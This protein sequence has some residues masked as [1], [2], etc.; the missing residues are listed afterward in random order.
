MKPGND[1]E[2]TSFAWLES[3]RLCR[4]EGRIDDMISRYKGLLSLEKQPAEQL[5]AEANYW[6]G[7][8]I[9]K[10]SAGKD[11]SANQSREAV[12]FLE[13]ARKLRPDTYGKHAGLLL[14]LVYFGN[15]DVPA[16]NA[17]L[18]LAIKKKYAA[19]VPE[20]ALSWAGMQAFNSEEYQR[21]ERYLKFVANPEEPR[22]T[23]KEIW[24]YLA[25][26]QLETGSFKDALN[27]VNNVLEVEDNPAWKADG[28][29]DKG[30]ALLELNRL[31]EAREAADEGLSMVPS[32]RTLAGLR[33]LSGDLHA[34][35]SELEKAGAQYL[36]LLEFHADQDLRPKALYRLTQVLEKQGKP[37]E[38][39]KYYNQLASDFPD[40]RPPTPKTAPDQ[41]KA[42]RAPDKTKPAA[43]APR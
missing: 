26:A 15:Q 37:E 29:L 31:T 13:T 38:A 41:P 30:R 24:R 3:A 36:I 27:A 1:A 35:A 10:K 42:P 11:P 21:A 19:D 5:V 18:D 33:M 32:G 22:E 20:Q 17:E 8:G 39:K 25:K 16:L 9:T 4:A 34:L 12:P 43:P 2:L 6:V 14:I 23:P 40:W 28:L 7:Q